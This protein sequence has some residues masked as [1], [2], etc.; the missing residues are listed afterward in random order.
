[1]S[2]FSFFQSSRSVAL[3]TTIAGLATSRFKQTESRLNRAKLWLSK[4]NFRP[5]KTKFCIDM[6]SRI[7]CCLVCFSSL[8][9]RSKKISLAIEQSDAPK[10]HNISS[11]TRVYLR[12]FCSAGISPNSTVEVRS[13]HFHESR[14]VSFYLT[15]HMN[16]SCTVLPFKI[17]IR[18]AKGMASQ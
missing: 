3:T 9:H 18:V 12:H 6:S 2:E 13:H 8:L 4:A 16:C 7:L 5:S 10:F 1:M 11:P 17:Y 14:R 15:Y